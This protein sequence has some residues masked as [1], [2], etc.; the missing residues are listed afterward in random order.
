M[1]A[2][3]EKCKAG[4]ITGMMRWNSPPFL[5]TSFCLLPFY[6]CLFLAMSVL[7]VAASLSGK[8]RSQ[9]LARIALHK[10]IDVGQAATLLDLREHPLPFGGSAAGWSDPAAAKL[11]ELTAAATRILFA[12]PV[13]NYDVNAVAKNFIE[14]MGEDALGQKT[15]GFMLSAG[16]GGSYMAVMP[17]ANSL[18]LDFRCWIVP[19]FL[20]VP[21]DFEGET[22]PAELDERLD[23]LL[24]DLL[25]RGL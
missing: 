17:F 7:I 20:Y 16:G 12:V 19:R 21:K 15:V 23:G 2:I 8:S 18:M 24:R 3:G 5:L 9:R 25:T 6:F 1:K 10:L 22:L 11:R 4:Q 14:L 13:Y